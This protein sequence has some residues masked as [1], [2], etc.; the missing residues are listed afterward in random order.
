MQV[1]IVFTHPTS[2]ILT[3][4]IGVVELFGFDTDLPISKDLELN[5][6]KSLLLE[7]RFVKYSLRLGVALK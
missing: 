5:E 6:V 7:I 3:I 4:S 2:I 1:I